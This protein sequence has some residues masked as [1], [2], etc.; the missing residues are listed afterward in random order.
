MELTNMLFAATQP[1]SGQTLATLISEGKSWPLIHF[2]SVGSG[3]FAYLASNGS[4]DL[5]TAVIDRLRGPQPVVTSPPDKRVVLTWQAK[6]RRWILHLM[7]AGD[8]AVHIRSD[9]AALKRVAGL[10]PATGWR[11][12]MRPDESG[13]QLEVSGGAQNRMVVLE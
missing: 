2:N 5:T 7:A 8:Y 6:P 11:A 13:V 3:R 12:D 1:R 9:Y 4:R 10:Y